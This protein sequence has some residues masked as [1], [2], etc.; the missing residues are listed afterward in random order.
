MRLLGGLRGRDERQGGLPERQTSA[1]QADAT[2]SAVGHSLEDLLDIATQY[3]RVLLHQMRDGCWHC[4]IE[5]NTIE[6]VKLEA[7]SGFYTKAPRESVREAVL[8]A[9]GI[10]DSMGG[11]QQ[12]RRIS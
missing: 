11:R 3:G 7:K 12:P 4:C 8:K 9:Q 5:F 2:A 10:V 6:G 1:A